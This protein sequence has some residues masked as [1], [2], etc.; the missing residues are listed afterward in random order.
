MRIHA[1]IQIIYLIAL[2]AL[3]VWALGQTVQPSW[4]QS[5]VSPPLVTDS[6][7]PTQ[8]YIPFVEPAPETSPLRPAIQTTFQ[9]WFGV[10]LLAS[11][12]TWFVIGVVLFGGV[13][14]GLVRLLGK[15]RPRAT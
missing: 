12:W 13:A 8:V 15:N 11:P 14:W 4:G 7:I 3:C 2:T 5:P 6:P 10:S 9:D 1:K